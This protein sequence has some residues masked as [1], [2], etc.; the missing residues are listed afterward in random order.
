MR[1]KKQS[2]VKIKKSKRDLHPS[3]PVPLKQQIATVR[4]S[5]TLCCNAT[6]IISFDAISTRFSLGDIPLA[7]ISKKK[8]KGI[9]ITLSSAF[10]P[11]YTFLWL[12]RH[13]ICTHARTN[14][15][16]PSWTHSLSLVTTAND[17]EHNRKRYSYD[18]NVVETVPLPAIAAIFPRLNHIIVKTC[19]LPRDVIS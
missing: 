14:L 15:N 7:R 2:A 11:F 16:V 5:T 1:D 19:F 9:E 12:F 10:Q 13:G 18:V 8:K 3:K 4:R 17:V 6:M